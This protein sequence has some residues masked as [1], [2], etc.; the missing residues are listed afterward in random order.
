MALSDNAFL[1]GFTNS[2][3]TASVLSAMHIQIKHKL[4]GVFDG[5]TIDTASNRMSV[6]D[7]DQY[8]AYCR[9]LGIRVSIKFLTSKLLRRIGRS[10]IVLV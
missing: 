1:H 2:P 8:D 4:G 5:I 3:G 9:E 10:E 6:M 7:T